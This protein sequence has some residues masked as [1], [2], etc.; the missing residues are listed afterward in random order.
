MEAV[1]RKEYDARIEVALQD[2][3]KRTAIRNQQLAEKNRNAERTVV[4]RLGYRMELARAWDGLR[5]KYTDDRMIAHGKARKHTPSSF[6]RLNYDYYGDPTRAG[7][8]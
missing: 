4:T 6:A 5:R 3:A 8:F 2:L 1:A 7:M